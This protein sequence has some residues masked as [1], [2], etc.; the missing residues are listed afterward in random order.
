MAF[1]AFKSFAK[2]LGGGLKTL[3]QAQRDQRLAVCGT[4]EHHTGVRCRVCGCFTSVKTWLPH[5]RCPIGKW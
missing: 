2:F 5:E 1:T 3:P 4:C